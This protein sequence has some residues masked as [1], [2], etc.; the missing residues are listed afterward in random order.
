LLVFSFVG[1]ILKTIDMLNEKQFRVIYSEFL[2]SGLTIRD[3]CANQQMNEAKFY[4]WQN[5]LKEQLQLKRGFVPVIFENGRQSQVPSPVQNLSESCSQPAVSN[6]T[7]SCE[8]NYP[9]GV[10]V[11]LNGLPDTQML[12]SLLVLTR[13]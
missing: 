4:Y 9:N 13:R 1:L 11:K 7:I 8:I 12:K 3:Y 5:K 6:K 2:E 10:S